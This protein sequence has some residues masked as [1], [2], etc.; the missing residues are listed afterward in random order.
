MNYEKIGKFIQEKRK[1]QGLTQKQLAEKIGITDKAVSKWER[2]LGCP[3]VSILELLSDILNVSILEILKGRTIENEIIKITEANDYVKE[4]ITYTKNKTKEIINRIITFLI[5]SIALL[6]LI[7]N[8]ENIMNMNKKYKYNFDTE[9]HKQIK[10]NVK[11][12]EKNT[13]IILNN[14]GKYK[15]EDYQ[16]I[17]KEI[18]ENLETIKNI[19]IIYETGEKTYTKNEIYLLNLKE[20]NTMSVIN[21]ARLIEKYNNDKTYMKALIDTTYTRLLLYPNLYDSYEYRL[22]KTNKENLYP[23]FYNDILYKKIISLKTSIS[24]YLNLTEQIKKVGEINE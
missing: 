10:E 4:T 20:M 8:I 3:D 22:F 24:T 16:E 11:E 13:N 7:L 2:G 9:S 5:I 23:L 6:L 14:K 15:E 19:K 17:C 21:L 12:I 18:K 1:Q